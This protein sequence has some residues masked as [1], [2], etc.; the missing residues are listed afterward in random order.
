MAGL[1]I[2]Q[3]GF[4]LGIIGGNLILL[5]FLDM[6]SSVPV[7]EPIGDILRG[8]GLVTVFSIASRAG[9]PLKYLIIMGS[10]IGI[11]LFFMSP[12]QEIH[13]TSSM[14]FGLP[15]FENI[16]LGTIMIT[17]SVIAVAIMTRLL[18]RKKVAS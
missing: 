17:I 7:L 9:V 15:N 5:G 12:S 13:M 14:G 3:F 16:S 10:V 11:G 18:L 8:L 6:G 2:H 1:A 4:A